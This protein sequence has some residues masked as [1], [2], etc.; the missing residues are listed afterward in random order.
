[1]SGFEKIRIDS[2]NARVLCI[3]DDADTIA[4]LANLLLHAG[5]AC[6]CCHDV[7]AARKSL[8]RHLPDLIIAD[9]NIGSD[10]GLELF[11]QLQATDASLVEVPLIVLSNDGNP[12]VVRQ[13][14]AA[15]AAY[16]L[17]KPFDP[18]VMLELVDKSLWMPH[19]VRNRVHGRTTA[20]AFEADR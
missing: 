11:Q 8:Q 16:Y 20:R 18:N 13:A 12:D 7:D 19:I 10:T 4:V 6:E 14:R 17:S 9:L 3:D 1:M 5:F 2:A 15:G